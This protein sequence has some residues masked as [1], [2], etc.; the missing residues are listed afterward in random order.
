VE[1]DP[2]KAV[3]RGLIDRYLDG[4]DSPLARSLLDPDREEVA[5]RIDPRRLHAWDYSGRM[6]GA[7]G[8]GA[9]GSDGSN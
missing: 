4:D 6:R 9:D 1:S 5:I 3:L 2:E 8:R 7:V